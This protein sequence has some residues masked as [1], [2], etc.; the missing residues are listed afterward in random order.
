MIALPRK[1]VDLGVTFSALDPLDTSLSPRWHAG[2]RGSGPVVLSARDRVEWPHP[3][4]L[5]AALHEGDINVAT[6]AIE[7]AG[8]MQFIWM[9]RTR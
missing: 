2:R 9:P 6:E 1:A 3:A 7:R 4:R 5:E 8:F